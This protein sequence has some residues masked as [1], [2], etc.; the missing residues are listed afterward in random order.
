MASMV[1]GQSDHTST[2]GT[3]YA[4][5]IVLLLVICF[6]ILGCSLCYEKYALNGESNVPPSAH[7]SIAASS[8]PVPQQEAAAPPSNAND[9]AIAVDGPK[10]TTAAQQDE[11]DPDDESAGT[12]SAQK[13]PPHLRMS[14]VKDLVA[15][16]NPAE[17][18]P[19]TGGLLDEAFDEVMQ[20]VI[21]DQEKAPNKN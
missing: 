19:V 1:M 5:L 3:T 15:K 20:D 10:P 14:S 7:A 21:A 9:V 16:A 18:T 11:Q 4:L 8:V 2:S 12:N 13:P 6:L 17:S